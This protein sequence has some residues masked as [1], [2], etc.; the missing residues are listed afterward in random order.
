MQSLEGSPAISAAVFVWLK[1]WTVFVTNPQPSCA[2]DLKIST[3]MIQSAS[4]SLHF[5]S[6]LFW[7]EI[8]ADQGGLLT[9]SSIPKNPCQQKWSPDLSCLFL[10]LLSA[11]GRC[12]TPSSTVGGSIALFID[13]PVKTRGR[14]CV[15]FWL[16]KAIPGEETS[17][18]LVIFLF[19]LSSVFGGFMVWWADMSL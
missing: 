17:L 2:A 19:Q 5:S 13:L 10:L 7:R 11:G 9:P 14:V 1:T 4:S 6:T 12:Y 18:W 3:F 8:N 15:R 16:E